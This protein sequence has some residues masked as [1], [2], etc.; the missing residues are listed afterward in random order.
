MK[1]INFAQV[2]NK[3]NSVVAELG[4]NKVNL[5]V[6]ASM[7]LNIEN[8]D[9]DFT[10]K[11]KYNYGVRVTSKTLEI[12]FKGHTESSVNKDQNCNVR[13]RIKL[14]FIKAILRTIITI[15][16]AYASIM[17]LVGSSIANLKEMA[18]T[19]V[20]F[21]DLSRKS[22]VK[23]KDSD[24]PSDAWRRT[25]LIKAAREGRLAA[26]PFHAVGSYG[27]ISCDPNINLE[28]YIDLFTGCGFKVYGQDYIQV[29][30]DSDM[31]KR[32]IMGRLMKFTKKDLWNKLRSE[33]ELRYYLGCRGCKYTKPSSN[34]LHLELD[35]Y[36]QLDFKDFEESH[37]DVVRINYLPDY[38]CLRFH[39]RN[40]CNEFI[41]KMKLQKK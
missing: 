24:K 22:P 8:T 34:R 11:V 39:K 2:E 10:S 28:D 16:N 38:V 20:E 33:L 37:Q 32:G 40:E 19:S 18:K 15:W 14:S 29:A 41:N 6:D 30:G 17:D 25:E 13:I 12:E 35:I 26:G 9:K 23:S 5:D 3:F 4:T 27:V 36:N 31:E 21:T 1:Q 7:H